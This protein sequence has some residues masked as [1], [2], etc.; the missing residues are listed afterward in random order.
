MRTSELETIEG[1]EG[2]AAGHSSPEERTK[3]LRT[4]VSFFRAI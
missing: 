2:P 4:K 3:K 1:R